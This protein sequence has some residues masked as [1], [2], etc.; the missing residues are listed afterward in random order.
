[1]KKAIIIATL[2]LPLILVAAG[3]S[4]YA[5]G[6]TTFHDA[7]GRVTGHAR[8]DRSGVTT[9]HDAAG[10]VTGR[11]RTDRGGITIYT[12]AAGRV[13]GRRRGWRR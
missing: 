6:T 2:S 3:N 13:T 1:M 9:F 12:D 8:T 4:A 11:A 5:G 7:A 10:R